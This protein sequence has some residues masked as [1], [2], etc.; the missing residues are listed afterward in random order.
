[1]E[2]A[3]KAW[4]DSKE[5]EAQPEQ[6]SLIALVASHFGCQS[7]PT[8]PSV[9]VPSAIAS[10]AS[11]VRRALAALSALLTAVGHNVSPE[12]KGELVLVL[13]SHLV[14]VG[15]T[16]LCICAC[17]CICTCT[18]AFTYLCFCLT[19]LQPLSCISIDSAF[20]ADKKSVDSLLESVL[21]EKDLMT[22]YLLVDRYFFFLN[23]LLGFSSNQMP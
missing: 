3:L 23:S 19:S 13:W 6:R 2:Q 22:R 7:T 14:H 5:Q 15:R 1:M 17:P 20:D 16:G 8:V 4:L 11:L 9:L 12:E 10:T 21:P 18:S